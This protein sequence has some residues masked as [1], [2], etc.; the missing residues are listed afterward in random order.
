VIDTRTVTDSLTEL[1][2]TATEQAVGKGRRP[3]NAARLAHYY[4]V[5]FITRTTTGAPFSD[6]NEDA[7]LTYQV[8]SVSGPDP[9]DPT[10]FGTQ[11]QLQWLDDAARRAVLGRNPAT[12]AWLHPMTIPG[13]RV[14]GRRAAGE[15]GESPDPG[16]AI[17]SSAQRFTFTVSSP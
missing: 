1:L 4:I 12:G 10:S 6:L 13:A 16:D 8:T 11:N 5:Y 2:A 15:Q 9:D 14:T 3:D 17:M 7:E